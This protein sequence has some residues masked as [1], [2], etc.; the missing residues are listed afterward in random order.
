MFN[1]LFE[2]HLD[3]L[4]NIDARLTE[5]GEIREPDDAQDPRA[6][7]STKPGEEGL[8]RSSHVDEAG[9]GWLPWG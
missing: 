1:V 3:S 2:A 9:T 6:W 4:D 8:Q 7:K 5:D